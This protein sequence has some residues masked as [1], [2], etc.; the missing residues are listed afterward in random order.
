[1]L[2]GCLGPLQDYSVCLRY[3][4]HGLMKEFWVVPL[5]PFKGIMSLFYFHIYFLWCH[6]LSLTDTSVICFQKL[7]DNGIAGNIVFSWKTYRVTSRVL[8]H[9]RISP[10]A[11]RS[12]SLVIFQPLRTSYYI[13]GNVSRWYIYVFLLLQCFLCVFICVQNASCKWHFFVHLFH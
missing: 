5:F 7:A 2:R 6:P 13:W 8:T 1:M 9:L 12:M 3:F 4:F 10:M 11:S